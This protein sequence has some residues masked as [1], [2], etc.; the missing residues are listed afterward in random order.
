MCGKDRSG[1][2][3][4]E[5]WTFTPSLERPGAVDEESSRAVSVRS[6]SLSTLFVEEEPMFST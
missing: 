2:L 4:D 1:D 3:W 5:S 6:W